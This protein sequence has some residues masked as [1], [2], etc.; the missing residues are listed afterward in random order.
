MQNFV[1]IVNLDYKEFYFLAALDAMA[2]AETALLHNSE[3]KVS[4]EI[5]LEGGGI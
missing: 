2:F 3:I 4:I 5:K 1:Y